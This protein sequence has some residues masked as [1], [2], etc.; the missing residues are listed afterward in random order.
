MSAREPACF[1]AI[2]KPAGLSSRAVVDRVSKTVG[3]RRVGHA[4]TLDP[5][6]T[7]VLVVA[8]ERATRL[9]EYVQRMRKRYR[10]DFLLGATSPTDDVE[11]DPVSTPGAEPPSEEAIREAISRQVGEILQVPPI[12]SAIK[13]SGKRAYELAR[14]GAEPK[15]EPR[16]VHVHRIDVLEYEY[17]HLRIDVECGSGTYIRSIARDLGNSLGV[18]GLM[19]ELRRTAVGVFT[20]EIAIPLDDLSP[21]DWRG[22]AR[23]LRFALSELP[24]IAL[25]AEGSDSF[26]HGRKTLVPNAPDGEL[27]VVDEQDRLLGIGRSERGGSLR[28]LKGGFLEENP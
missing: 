18:G 27:V 23:T 16:P 2:D 28:P 5:L 8:V 4:G 10:A 7:G 17:P 9:I 26:R 1:L 15:I 21:T 20:E 12:Y 25:D 6:A 13:L 3:S 11:S 22:F 19:K 24:T 14:R